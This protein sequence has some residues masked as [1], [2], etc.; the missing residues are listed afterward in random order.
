MRVGIMMGFSSFR[1]L[2]R[3][4]SA[5][6][7][8]CSAPVSATPVARVLAFNKSTTTFATIA[9]GTVTVGDKQFPT[10]NDTNVTPTILN[11][12]GRGLLHVPNHPLSILKNKIVA[13]M[14]DPKKFAGAG[15]PEFEVFDD[16][17]PAVT[18]TANFDNILIDEDH[19]SRSKNDNYFI[20]KHHLLRAHT[21]AHQVELMRN[22]AENFLVAGDV[23]RR[24]EIDQ[25]HYPV[26][27]Q[28]EGVRMFSITEMNQLTNAAVFDSH[29]HTRTPHTQELH[30]E[31]TT[32]CLAADLKR[33][34]ESLVADLFGDVE[35]RWVDC[36]FPFTHPSYELEIFFNGEWLEVLGCGVMEQQVLENGHADNKVGWAFGLGLERLAMVL[37]DIPDIR[38]FWSEDARFLEQFDENMPIRQQKF[39]PFSKYPACYKDLAFWVPDD[40]SPNSFAEIVRGVAGDLVEEVKE[41]DQFRHPKTQRESR[42]YRTMYRAMDRNL[43]NEEINALQVQACS[44]EPHLTC[45]M[46]YPH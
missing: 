9:N 14:Q 43:T 26:F 45:P 36:Y 18:T 30:T 33:V 23:Y 6:P 15:M 13:H 1:Y 44:A 22:G 38:L 37:Y 11:K 32:A 16:Q 40:F 41:I 34:L 35:C 5:L 8:A 31:A 27:H 20:N 25:S 17:N 46:E 10:D 39:K 21:S 24:D 28:M 42:C 12:V 29:N 7:A 19:V 4:A 3:C 2:Q